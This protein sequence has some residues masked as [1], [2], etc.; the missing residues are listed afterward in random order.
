MLENAPVYIYATELVGDYYQTLGAKGGD[1]LTVLG[2]GDQMINAFALGANT[3]ASFDLNQ[4]AKFIAELK[5]SAIEHETYESFLSFFGD[6]YSNAVFG[7]ATYNRLRGYLTKEATEFFDRIY[8]E[9]KL[10]GTQPAHHSLFRQRD[11]LGIS[12]TQVNLYMKDEVFYEKTRS[13]LSD[14]EWPFMQSDASKVSKNLSGQFDLINLSNVP[15]YF[16]RK[17]IDGTSIEVLTDLLHS[18]ND[19]LKPGGQIFYYSY[20]PESY[21]DSG[22]PASRNETLDELKATLPY[23]IS[24]MELSGSMSGLGKDRVVILK[25]RQ[26]A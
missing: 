9:S 22:P 18:F 15:N 7:R 6:T 21:E 24:V 23:D 8:E 16:Y 25:K 4:N 11:F 14:R 20:A 5:V 13:A 3:V 17:E 12:P 19:F 1:I 10:S 2:S 26:N